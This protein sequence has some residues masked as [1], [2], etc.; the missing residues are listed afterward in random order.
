MTEHEKTGKI[1]RT[2][3]GL[4]AGI[5]FLGI[6]GELVGILFIERKLYYTIGWLYGIAL[7][8]FMAWHMWRALDKGL[9]RNEASATKYMML[10]NMIRYAVVAVCYI[11]LVVL[12]IGNP[13][14]AFV[15]LLTLKPAAYLQPF[16]DKCL[17]GLLH[18]EDEL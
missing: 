15:G 5:L 9:D 8:L 3:L 16:A 6:L 13:I 4:F 14:A 17:K 12:D 10:S 11:L 1:N 18:W 2:L 7:S